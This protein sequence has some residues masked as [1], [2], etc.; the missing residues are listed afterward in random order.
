MIPI[1]IFWSIQI[2]RLG[3]N[4]RISTLAVQM[5]ISE[6]PSLPK[7]IHVGIVS[8]LLAASSASHSYKR[9]VSR[10]CF[11]TSGSNIS[12]SAPK[13]CVAAFFCSGLLI[14]SSH[15]LF[16]T[17]TDWWQWGPTNLITFFYH[18]TSYMSSCPLTDFFF[19]SGDT[20]AFSLSW[21]VRCNNTK[22]LH[23]ANV[24]KYT[25]SWSSTQ[26]LNLL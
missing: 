1:H 16:V 26:C 13:P 25:S 9:Q 12:P 7:H 15:R 24:Y 2:K 11:G 4:H 8:R 20:A 17:R 3:V 22:L 5:I 23:C 6:I 21:C 10:P 14:S 18:V 19:W